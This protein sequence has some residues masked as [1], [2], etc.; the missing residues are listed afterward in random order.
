MTPSR[1]PQH[2]PEVF[3]AKVRASGLRDPDK[4][5]D[6]SVSSYNCLGVR[7]KSRHGKAQEYEAMIA[8]VEAVDARLRGLIID[9]DCNSRAEI[10]Y[11]AT[12]KPCCLADA[13]TI[14]RQL[15]AGCV[16]ATKGHNGIYVRGNGGGD[17]S[18]RPY[19][20]TQG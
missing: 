5:P 8:M 13:N 1:I 14:A 6:T 4:V 7:L 15:E 20:P 11:A 2:E 3:A 17:V 19:R 10:C 12:L 9:I 18:R 16:A